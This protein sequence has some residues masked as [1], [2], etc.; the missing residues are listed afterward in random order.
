M[1]EILREIIVLDDD[2]DDN[3]DEYEDKQKRST[4]FNARHDNRDDSLEIISSR[5]F[6]DDVQMP[7]VDYIN[8]GKLTPHNRRYSDERDGGEMALDAPHQPVPYTPQFQVD[9]P[10]SNGTTAHHHR[11]QEAFHS[12][13]MNQAPVPI[14]H[15]ASLPQEEQEEDSPRRKPLLRSRTRLSL[16]GSDLRATHMDPIDYEKYMQLQDASPPLSLSLR[17]KPS[18]ANQVTGNIS[19]GPKDDFT[20]LGQVSTSTDETESDGPAL[21]Y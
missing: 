20:E 18:L 17:P 1:E 15:N 4:S 19:E 2:D 3:D 10:R 13:R 14:V 8:A 11:W 5:A 21:T 9:P 12:R 6:T 16:Q 7:A